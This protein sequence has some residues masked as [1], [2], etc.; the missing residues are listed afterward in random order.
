MASSKCPKCENTQF[1]SVRVKMSNNRSEFI[2]VQCN[3]CG[4]VVGAFDTDSLINT[5][6][7]ILRALPPAKYLG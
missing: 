1:E 6:N 5:G 4:C 7:A 2:F 3:K